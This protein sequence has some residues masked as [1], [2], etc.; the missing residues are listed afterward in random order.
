MISPEKSAD[1]KVLAFRAEGDTDNDDDV[2][3]RSIDDIDKP[4]KDQISEEQQKELDAFARGDIEKL[5]SK[6]LLHRFWRTAR[7]FWR[8]KGGD[9]LAWVLPG[10]PPRADPAESCGRKYGINFWN[11]AIFDALEKH[12][13]AKVLYLSAIFFPLAAV[14]VRIGMANVYARMSTQRRWRAWMADL[15]LA[16]GSRTA[17]TISSISSAAIIRIRKGGSTEDLRVATDAPVD[18][19][20]GMLHAAL[21]ALTFIVVL[22]TIG[23][24]LT[25]TVGGAA[26]TIPGF[27]VIAAVLYAVV[28][29]GA[30]MFVGSSFVTVSEAKNQT[31][32][33]YR[34]PLTRVRENGE[35]IALLG[36]EEEERAGIDRSLE[37]CCGP[38][39][40]FAVS[41]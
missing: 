15:S 28:A 20:V 12:D 18:F 11:R 37:R 27:L 29:S 33:E 35:S 31:E 34:Y 38:G 9:R 6:Y 24:A 4:D 22:W 39:A 21:S 7:G 30:M 10:R 40:S 19:A 2:N 5:R 13:S 1:K 17:A 32:A 26:V 3:K 41:T 25:I 16:D 23:G 14:S 8:R 36:G